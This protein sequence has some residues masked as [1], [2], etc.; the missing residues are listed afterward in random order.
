MQEVVPDR[1]DIVGIFALPEIRPAVT[2][3]AHA[4]SVVVFNVEKGVLVTHGHPATHRG[5]L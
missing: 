5:G 2:L 1:H 4:V 3:A